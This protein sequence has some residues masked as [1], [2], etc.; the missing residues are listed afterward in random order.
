MC[1]LSCSNAS[2][3]NSQLF[4]EEFSNDILHYFLVSS[5]KK[6][7]RLPCVEESTSEKDVK[8]SLRLDSPS[9]E[10]TLTQFLQKEGMS[11]MFMGMTCKRLS[12]PK[13]LSVPLSKRDR[14]KFPSEG[15]HYFFGRNSANG[16]KKFWSCEQKGRCKARI[17]TTGT[18]VVMEIGERSHDN[19]AAAVEV[20]EL[21]TMIRRH[22][23]DNME[24]SVQVINKYAVGVSQGARGSLK[25]LRAHKKVVIRRRNEVIAN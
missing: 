25:N 15:F 5:V 9:T 18:T 1:C 8:K 19:S 10:A 12:V 21:V 16:T 2:E 20:A 3:T 23:E 22:A 7:L 6:L 11:V 17:H 14:K 4:N 24:A 13:M